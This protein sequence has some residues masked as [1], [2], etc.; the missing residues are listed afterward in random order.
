MASATYRECDC[1]HALVVERITRR[2]VYLVLLRKWT[3]WK[4][5]SD[6]SIHKAIKSARY[7]NLFKLPHLIFGTSLTTVSRPVWS[8]PLILIF[9]Q[10]FIE[11][12]D[13]AITTI[14]DYKGGPFQQA[15]SGIT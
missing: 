12:Y 7:R 3:L 4:H 1:Q 13:P 2:P 8:I 9:S 15:C 14:N 10:E 11:L 5:L 6:I